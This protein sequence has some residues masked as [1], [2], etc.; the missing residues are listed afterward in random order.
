MSPV[1]NAKKEWLTTEH[2]AVHRSV[3]CNNPCIRKSRQMQQQPG[4]NYKVYI[5]SNFGYQLLLNKLL[6]N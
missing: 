5:D 1:N 4:H 3:D 6:R 2:I